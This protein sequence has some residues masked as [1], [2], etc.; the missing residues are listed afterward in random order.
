MRQ[1]WNL[2]V[3]LWETGNWWVRWAIVVLVG[4][5]FGMLF[6]A[7]LP[8]AWAITV[9]PILAFLPLFAFMGV[10]IGIFDPLVVAIIL[11]FGWG[12]RIFA[13]I[14][15]VIVL[16]LALGAFLAV[17]PLAND[18][19]LVPLLMLTTLTWIVLRPVR[20]GPTVTLRRF[21][22]LATLV[23]IAIFFLGGRE[24]A[25][26]RARAAGTTAVTTGVAIFGARTPPENAYWSGYV[27]DAEWKEVKLPAYPNWFQVDPTREVLL[28]LADGNTGEPGGET[29]HVS[30]GGAIRAF[31]DGKIGERVMGVGD[32]IAGNK[33]FLRSYETGPTLVTIGVSEKKR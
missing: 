30:R 12:R 32:N 16:E 25:E 10:L 3:D 14:A 15:G 11:A 5:P 20:L 19:P 6:A 18:R 26:V 4:S 7:L 1:V 22:G 27:D 28:I 13:L 23:L 2:L 9:V 33:F 29:F 8:H 17:M 24:K 31:K 21:A